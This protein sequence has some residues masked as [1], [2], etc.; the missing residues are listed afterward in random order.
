M[1]ASTNWV[2]IDD[3]VQEAESFAQQLGEGANLIQVE[4]LN[5]KQARET[6]L[7]GQ[8]QPTGVLVDVDLSAIPGEYG[9]GPG[10]AQDIRINQKNRKLSEFP[11]VRF[12][13]RQRV[14]ANVGGDPASD[15]L[16]DLK[17]QKEELARDLDSVQGRLRG[18]QEIYESL[19]SHNAL[20]G[21]ALNQFLGLTDE[22]LD[23]WSHPALH[24]RI[25]ADLH[26]A[27]HVA[28]LLFMRGVLQPT[29]LLV[30][31]SILAFRLGI[32]KAA[33]GGA[34]RQLLKELEAVKYHGVASN[35]FDRWWARGVEDWWLD[36][37]GRG[38]GL[39]NLDISERHELLKGRFSDLIPLK[40]PHGSAGDKPW[41]ACTLSLEDE[42]PQWIPVDP[43]AA[44]RVAPRSDLPPWVDPLYAALGPALQSQDL[45]V[46]K[47]DLAR[48]SKKY[49]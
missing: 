23:A 13:F 49:R 43:T 34:W 4:V 6:L 40:M 12:A 15:D 24:E 1:A 11:V 38:S 9:S 2:F 41:R 30:N 31:E 22:G 47:E 8:L 42:P 5:P 7:S 35:H 21:E 16:F 28:A 19:K 14:D 45:R 18:A 37:V 17:I 3:Q 48:L 32:D 25:A 36:N 27:P 29:G 46:N 26:V 39:A 44:V 20:V 10:I 33:S